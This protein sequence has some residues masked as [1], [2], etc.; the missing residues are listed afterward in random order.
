[1]NLMIIYLVWPKGLF[2]MGIFEE[3]NHYLPILTWK[4]VWYAFN[5]YLPRLT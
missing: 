2:D 5:D 1:M 3:F 4:P